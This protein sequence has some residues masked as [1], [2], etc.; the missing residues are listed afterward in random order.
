MLETEIKKLTAAVEQLT[1]VMSGAEAAELPA[2]V[3]APAVEIPIAAAAAPVEVPAA[4]APA[5]A[6]VLPTP[7]IPLEIPAPAPSVATGANQ[8]APA[9]SIGKKEVTEAAI[10]VGRE[11]SSAVLRDV[12]AQFG[13]TNIS[14]IKPEQYGAA[15]QALMAVLA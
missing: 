13:A 8:A 5:A 12:L 2:V 11:K 14:G 4:V 3:P 1:S 9:G 6:I 7:T 10:K 15:H